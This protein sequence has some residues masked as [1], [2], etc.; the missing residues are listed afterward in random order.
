MRPL[1]QLA[2]GALL[3]LGGAVPA[4]A[5]TAPEAAGATLYAQ[6]CAVCHQPAGTG[7]VPHFPALAG[8]ARLRDTELLVRTLHQ[9]RGVMPGFPELGAEELAAVATHVRSSWGNNFGAVAAAEVVPVLAAARATGPLA[10]V[11]EGVFSREQ[12][13]R[14]RQVIRTACAECHGTRLDGQPLDP[15][16]GPSPAIARARFLRVWDGRSLASLYAYTKATMPP[17][18][19]GALSEAEY[20]EAIAQMLATSGVPAGET[21]LTA[22]LAR[23][24]RILIRQQRN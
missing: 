11:W 15:D 23:L 20:L 9:G 18:T 19:P 13:E 12:A 3:L 6:R 7:A 14:G 17:S 16:R 22:D 1:P 10:S 2:L 5:Q 8:N 4:A 24:S 21:A